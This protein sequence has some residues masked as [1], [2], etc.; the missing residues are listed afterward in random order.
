MAATVYVLCAAASGVCA[1]LL[2]LG[3]LRTRTRLLLWSTLC[4]TLLTL[5]NVL[6][7]ADRLVWTGTD[8]ALARGIAGLSGLSLLALGLIWE[9]R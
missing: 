2:G 6:L 9:S 3:Y 7:V 5:N 4:F 8:L 1:L